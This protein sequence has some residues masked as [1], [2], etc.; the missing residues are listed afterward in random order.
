MDILKIEKSKTRT[1]ILRHFFANPDKKY[2]LRE[3]ER[4]LGVSVGNIRRELL[5]L[6]KAGLFD[7][8][9][10]GKQ[11]YYF[12]DKKS[13]IF[14][15][16]KKIAAKTIGAEAVLKEK[17]LRVKGIELAFIYGSAAREKEDE[18]SDMDIFIVGSINEDKLLKFIREAEKELSQEIN[19]VIFAA[20]DIEENIRKKDVFLADVIKGKKIFLIGD[21][22]DLE[23]IVSGRENSEKRH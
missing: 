8:K 2:Y 15:E 22:N 13:P 17:L 5:A 7:A 6:K 9:Q 4:I 23:K 11:L 3:L 16:F 19:Y 12:L 20:K 14:K 18:F 21:K 1:K 10:E